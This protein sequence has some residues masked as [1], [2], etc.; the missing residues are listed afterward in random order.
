MG[1]LRHFAAALS[2][3]A[4]AVVPA[5]PT[6]ANATSL[7]HPGASAAGNSPTPSARAGRSYQSIDP[8]PAASSVKIP[9]GRKATVSFAKL[10]ALP[11]SG[12]TQVRALV[13][14][15]STAK[16]S[17]TIRP[18]GSAGSS[19]LRFKAK[20]SKTAT[21][22][23]GPGRP[24]GWRIT[25]RGPRT[26]RIS[27]IVV[28]YWRA[29]EAEDGSGAPPTGSDPGRT[30]DPSPGP[31]GN[32]GRYDIGTFSGTDVWVN[33]ATGSDS[34]SGATRGSA[35]RT[36]G[37]AWGRIPRN[38]TLT[39]GYRIQLVAGTYPESV[40]VNYWEDR[41]GTYE[42]PIILNAVDG[43]HTVTFTGD[44][45]MFNTRYFYLIGVDISRDGDSFH[46]EQC[47]Y[48]LIRNSSMDGNP[49]SGDGDMAHETIKI[50]QSDHFYIEDSTISGADD[51]AIDFVAVQYGHLRGNRVSRA[52]DWCAYSKGGSAYLTIA[53]NEFYDC[54]TGGYTAGQGTGVQFTTSP[55]IYYEAMDIKV[56]NNVIHDTSGAGLGVN[57][58]YNILMAYNTIYRVGTRGHTVEFV[59]GSH[60]CD[61]FA[62][63]GAA[64]CAPRVDSGGWGTTGGDEAFI[65]NKHVYFYNNVIL[66]PV[67]NTSPQQF[68]IHG[69]LTQ[70]ASHNVANPARTDDDLRI[71]GN[72][73]WNGDADTPLGIGDGS[74]CQPSNATC[75]ESLITANNHINTTRPD[76]LDAGS[77]NF[78]P[79]PSGWLAAQSA[80]AIPSFGW[81]DTPNGAIPSGST[82]NSV[83]L[84]R[85]GNA[86]SG[87]GHPGAY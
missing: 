83:P 60:S 9:A 41:L 68:T 34:N 70:S 24:V 77:L 81:T 72:V 10:G 43:A 38:Q 71:A 29:A 78:L 52:Q 84:D 4:I 33:P 42:H 86:R 63:G 62:D 67:D 53:E 48:T 14:T 56:V 6:T 11:R 85:A 49:H 15:R 5:L 2:A 20:K 22:S 47:S 46:C 82:S 55:W 80:V 51:N 35:L 32:N 39:T 57:G 3:A 58:G 54:G 12:V 61:G 37:A 45:N 25:N 59:Y 30:I 18:R 36:V 19:S 13:S 44:I 64:Q 50:N 66:N 76:F 87:W 27:V 16:G 65:P 28:G 8:A 40:L 73:I 26:V 21:V 74:G 17:I 23:L 1:T 31:V 75:T 7:P 69:P 79:T